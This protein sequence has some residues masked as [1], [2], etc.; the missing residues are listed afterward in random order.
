MDK[1][2]YTQ[3]SRADKAINT[4]RGIAQGIL[5]DR[6]VNDKEIE[7]LKEWAES[8]SSTAR[9]KPFRE[10]LIS[11]SELNAQ[12]LEERISTIEDIYW[13]CQKFDTEESVYYDAL[14]SEIQTLIGFCHGII[15]DQV[16]ENSEIVALEKWLYEHEHLE[17]HFIYDELI[18]TV[19]GILSDGKID[20][21]ERNFL[22]SSL[23]SLSGP[24]SIKSDENTAP[25][26]DLIFTTQRIE[27]LE[28]QN[29]VLTG[30]FHW[31]G[32]SELTELLL[33]K[34]AIVSSTPSKKTNY[35]VIGEVGSEHWAY[36]RFGRKVEKAL[37][38]RKS[39]DTLHIVREVC[40]IKHL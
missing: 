6:I 5:A 23:E 34:G 3:K 27:M 1:P 38:L 17:G 39:I 37:E 2:W 12:T 19:Q 11:I 4:L 28:N 30:E 7:Q 31:G 13:L 15:I 20:E 21:A 26:N 9:K 24:G 25:R 29:F 14:T 10:F 16:L 18:K 22:F 8:M 32:R 40:L 33:D 35:V 36:S